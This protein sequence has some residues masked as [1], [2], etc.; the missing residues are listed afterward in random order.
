MEFYLGRKSY[1][2]D[3]RR[4]V[5]TLSSEHLSYYQYQSCGLMDGF[6]RQPISQML[7]HWQ[8]FSSICTCYNETLLP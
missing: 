5:G 3:A 4:S 8:S 6:I 2:Q 1:S 7:Q